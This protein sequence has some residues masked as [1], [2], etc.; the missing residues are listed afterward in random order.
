MAQTDDHDL[1]LSSHISGRPSPPALPP[2]KKVDFA[3]FLPE[4]YL[5][6]FKDGSEWGEGRA[7][8]KYRDL[9]PN[10]LGGRFIA[11]HIHIPEGGA[12]PDYVHYHNVHFQTIFVKKGWVKVVYEDQGPPFIMHAGDCVLQ[13][14]LIRHR[15]LES[16]PNL[17]VVEIGDPATHHTFV[18][19]HLQ[20]PNTAAPP[21]PNDAVRRWSG[22]RFHF[23]SAGM[24][25]ASDWQT[26][27]RQPQ[28]DLL[29]KDLGIGDATGGVA[30]MT[31]IRS[32]RAFGLSVPS[33]PPPTS[34]CFTH[35]SDFFL[36]VVLRGSC[37]LFCLPFAPTGAT[38]EGKRYTLEEGDSVVLPPSV[39]YCI[40]TACDAFEALEVTLPLSGSHHPHSPAGSPPESKL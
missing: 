10:R 28:S 9:C 3:R 36:L 7:G 17:E 37:S 16:S 5:S 23:H 35:H 38:E 13:P 26:W 15:V 19:H 20:L 27:H 22:Q 34:A 2:P 25:N 24:S 21:G 29:A 18:E 32:N 11:S 30:G 1:S 8:M 31:V 40:G 12:V 14:P 33:L 6:K 4:V 39:Q